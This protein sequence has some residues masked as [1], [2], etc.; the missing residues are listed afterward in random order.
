MLTGTRVRAPATICCRGEQV[1]HK[2]GV[3]TVVHVLGSAIYVRW[4]WTGDVYPTSVRQLKVLGGGLTVRVRSSQAK[5]PE[6]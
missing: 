3:G 6:N 1:I 2:G 4:D 5:A